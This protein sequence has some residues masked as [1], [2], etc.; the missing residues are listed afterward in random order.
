MNTAVVNFKTDPKIKKEAQKVVSEDGTTL[1]RVLQDYLKRIVMTKSVKRA[2][3]PY[4]MFPGSDI[5][6]K[7]I[8]EITHSWNKII[9]EIG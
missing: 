1:S 9:D 2:E 8:D 3:T 5:T 4:G 7:E 6:E